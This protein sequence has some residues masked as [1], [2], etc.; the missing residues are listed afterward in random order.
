VLTKDGIIVA[1]FVF[2][3]ALRSD[4]RAAVEQLN[5]AR[6]SVEMLSGDIAVACGEV[7]EML[8]IDRFVPAL[9]PSGKVE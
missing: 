3:D 9:L 8:R 6:I 5:N 2:E 1:S 4:A 7:A